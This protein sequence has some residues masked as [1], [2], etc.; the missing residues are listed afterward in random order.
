METQFWGEK[1]FC[2]KQ[3]F[4]SIAE[5]F[6]IKKVVAACGQEKTRMQDVIFAYLREN[7]LLSH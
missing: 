1:V 2:E 3:C 4:S 5:A 7:N 6:H